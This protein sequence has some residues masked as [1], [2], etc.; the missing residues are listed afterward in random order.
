MGG[1]WSVCGQ[2]AVAQAEKDLELSKTRSQNYT[3]YL[4]TW[5][6]RE[7]ILF[8]FFSN[9]WIITWQI[10]GTQHIFIARKNEKPHR[11]HFNTASETCM[12]ELALASKQLQLALPR[13][14]PS[15][16]IKAT[17]SASPVL[18]ICTASG[19]VDLG[20]SL[21]AQY[22]HRLGQNHALHFQRE[23]QPR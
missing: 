7:K 21:F 4:I 23:E 9:D 3:V 19:L 20:G 22:S 13:C 18:S 12:H 11:V 14:N 8:I 16:L 17:Y 1:K 5:N 15:F 10:I 2:L 6:I